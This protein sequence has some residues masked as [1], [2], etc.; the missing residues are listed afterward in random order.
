M[1]LQLFKAL[2]HGMCANWEIDSDLTGGI[3]S[4]NSISAS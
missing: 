2:A 1:P 3:N 4:R